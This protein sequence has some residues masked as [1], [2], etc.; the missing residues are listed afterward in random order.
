MI[1][2]I[3]QQIIRC[4]EGLEVRGLGETKESDFGLKENDTKME[5]LVIFSSNR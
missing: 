2:H 1:E 4:Q 3:Y 5:Y